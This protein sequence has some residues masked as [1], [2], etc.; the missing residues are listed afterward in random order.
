MDVYAL[1]PD[2]VFAYL[3]FIFVPV[4]MA[5][6]FTESTLTAAPFL[7]RRE[8][9]P[10]TIHHFYFTDGVESGRVKCKQNQVNTASGL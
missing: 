1:A 2:F 8:W 7:Q 3:I 9:N 10:N 4:A 6:V 5:A